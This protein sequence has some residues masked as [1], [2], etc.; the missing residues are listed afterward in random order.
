MPDEGDSQHQHDDEGGSGTAVDEGRPKLKEP[1]RYA[2]ILHNDDYTTMEF[3]IE[4]L[5][6]FFRKTHEESMQIT[7]RVHHEGKG[8]AGIYGHQIAET[9]AAQVAEYAKAQGFPLKASIE[10]VP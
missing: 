3:V 4:V 1:M 8:L 10:E 9:K 6:R 7:L 2:V 5:M